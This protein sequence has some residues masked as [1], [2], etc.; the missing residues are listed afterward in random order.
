MRRVERRYAAGICATVVPRQGGRQRD[1]MARRTGTAARTGSCTSV[2]RTA[3]TRGNACSGVMH[4]AAVG[5][6]LSPVRAAH[7]HS[8]SY[9]ANRPGVPM[10]LWIRLSI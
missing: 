6:G 9:A 5:D 3:R 7:R 8:H 1:A 2:R 10:A 4:G